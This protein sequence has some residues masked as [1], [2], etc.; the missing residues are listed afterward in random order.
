LE[1]ALPKK[2]KK[3][4]YSL[5]KGYIQLNEECSEAVADSIITRYQ[6]EYA[7]HR[8][9]IEFFVIPNFLAWLKRK[10]EK[11]FQERASKAAKARWA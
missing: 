7:Y 4:R 2:R 11:A 3:E 1:K 8:G 9:M 10:E 6:K 5:F